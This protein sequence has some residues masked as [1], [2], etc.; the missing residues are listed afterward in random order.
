MTSTQRFLAFLWLSSILLVASAFAPPTIGSAQR[1]SAHFSKPSSLQAAPIQV[2]EGTSTT[3]AAATLDPTTF[4]SD[5]L[6][7]FINSNLIL[8]VPIVAALAV[9]ALVAFGIVSYA[10]PAEPEDD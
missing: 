9:A 2:F 4:L 6:G 10:T 8:A 7:A 1:Y 3:I 5:L